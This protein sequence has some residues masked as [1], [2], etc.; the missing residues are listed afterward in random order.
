MSALIWQGGGLVPGTGTLA[1]DM[2]RQTGFR[3][4]STDLGLAAWDMLS[5]EGLL[6]RPPSVVLAGISGNMDGS[7]GEGRRTLG[8][9]VLRKAGARIRIA[10]FPPS[11]L[12]C[13]G[14]VIVRALARLAEVRRQEGG[15]AG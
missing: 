8:H 9:P 2:M 1:D 12:H 11:L 5:L 14:P 15:R 3:N 13:G 10:D 4:I 7:G 6:A